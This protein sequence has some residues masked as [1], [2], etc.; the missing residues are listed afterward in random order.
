M[1][2]EVTQANVHLFLP[3]K[4]ARL[5]GMIKQHS[6][7]SIRDAL[8]NIYR[9]EAYC[10]LEREETKLWHLSPEQIYAEYLQFQPH[11]NLKNSGKQTNL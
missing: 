8:L 1:P 7:A 2:P 4:T 5:A 11:I 10:L 6:N 3:Y 9:S